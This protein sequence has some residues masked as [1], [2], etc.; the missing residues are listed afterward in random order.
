MGKLTF[1]KVFF[2]KFKKR[3]PDLEKSLPN[4][5]GK[6][7]FNEPLAKKNWFGVGGMAQ[8]YFEP[9]DMDDLRSFIKQ[10]KG[11]PLTVLGAG[12]NVLIRDG[13]IPGITLRLGKAFSSIDVT[14]D[15]LICKGAALVMEVSRVAEKN[16]ISGFEFLCGIPGTVGGGIRMNAGAYGSSVH[17]ILESLTVLTKEGDVQVL[18]KEELTDAFSYRR[19]HL[20]TEWIF[21]EAVFRGKK[22]KDSLVIQQKMMTNKQKREA[23]QP[24]GVRTAGSTFKNPD[25]I[26]AWQLIEKAGMKNAKVGGA[27]VS[28]KHANFLINTGKATAKDIEELGELIRK[29]VLEKEGVSLE[30]E[31]R[32]LGVEEERNKRDR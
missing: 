16:A 20:P 21:L 27:C 32:K 6:L 15:T 7:L 28:S 5:R 8:I 30:W 1:F 31:V 11:V 29:K 2:D 23:G 4:V 10:T 18:S 22:E 19:C 24:I 13:G 25:G 12:S 14:N 17:E 3:F 26:P 9:A